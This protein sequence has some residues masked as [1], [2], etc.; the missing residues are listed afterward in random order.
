MQAPFLHGDAFLRDI[1]AHS[2]DCRLWWLGQSGFLVQWSEQHLLL[3][4]YLSDSLTRKYAATD[5][6]HV[7]MTGRVIPPEALDF[8]DVAVST[9]NH[10][11]HLDGETL[12]ALRRIN[13]GMR[14]IIPEANRDFVVR[15][16][17]CEAA[18]PIGLDDGRQ[19]RVGAFRFTGVPSAH[20]ALM[21][22]DRGQHHF[23]GYVVDFGPWTLYHPGDTM[24]YDGMVERLKPHRV[25]VALLPINGR[26]PARRVAGNLSGSEAARLAFEIGA[27]VVI[28][29]H[30]D[31]FE[32][33]TASPDA[34]RREA[35]ALGQPYHILRNGEGL[36]LN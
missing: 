25:D 31:M 6:P 9:H 23:L 7:R 28:P 35:E 15:R 12:L 29:C 16:L 21:R 4:P 36:T 14:L 5:K 17:Q 8:V 20:E 32:F 3:D 22:N 30:Y 13:P 27:K 24:L 11:D 26:D 33:N 1:A 18:W 34:F 2:H 10:T 19:A